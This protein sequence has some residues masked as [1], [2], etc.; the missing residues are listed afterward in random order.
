MSSDPGPQPEPTIEP[1]EPL[2]GGADALDDEEKYGAT[3]DVPT[4]PD[5]DPEANPAEEEIPDVLKQR[6]DE[7]EEPDADAEKAEDVNGGVEPP[8]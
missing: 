3:A 7:D 4:V 1:R 6:T 2:P 8:A 5:P